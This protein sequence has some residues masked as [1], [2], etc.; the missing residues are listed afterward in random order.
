M[1]ARIVI[2]LTMLAVASA[3]TQPKRRPAVV[4]GESLAVVKAFLEPDLYSR[5][6]PS[7]FVRSE[8]SPMNRA[9]GWGSCLEGLA[10]NNHRSRGAQQLPAALAKGRV[11]LIDKAQEKELYRRIAEGKLRYVLRLSEVVFDDT[12]RFAVVGRSLYCGST[13]ATSGS[14][15]FEK[16]D[17]KWKPSKRQCGQVLS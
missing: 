5:S 11:R 16:V 6:G 13:C 14:L 1:K 7:L 12:G 10:F 8:L 2:V 15:V 3:V 17:G 4:S 9:E